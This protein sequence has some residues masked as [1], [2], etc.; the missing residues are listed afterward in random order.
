MACEIIVDDIRREDWERY[1]GNFA[2][3]SIYQTWPYQQVR[4][5]MDGQDISRAVIKDENGKVATMCQIRIKHFKPLGLKIGYAQW[6]PLFRG[7]NGKITCSTQA[8][9]QMRKAY[10]PNK[11]NIL[12]LVP[13]V[14]NDE[15][16]LAFAEMLQSAGFQSYPVVQ[17]YRSFLLRVDD[18]EDG[19]RKRLRKSFRRDVKYAEKAGI[20]ISQDSSEEFCDILEKLYSLSLQRKKFQGLNLREFIR[21]Q[22]MLSAAERMNITVAYYDGEPAAVH[23]A[24]NLGDTAVVLLAASSEKGLECGASYLVW[25]KGAIAALKAGMKWYDLGGIDRDKNPNVYQFKSRMGGGEVMHIGAFEACTNSVVKRL[26]SMAE[27]TYTLV[28]K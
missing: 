1:A 28:K 9:Q 26:W 8:L 13:N 2:D 18:S 22:Q 7:K 25:Y 20:Q 4:A 19:I 21:P 10:L 27:K 24:S 11:V 15:V 23:L 6:G 16:G 17:P 5:E 14:R 12:R 3:Y